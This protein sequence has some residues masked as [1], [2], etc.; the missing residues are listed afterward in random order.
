MQVEL[1]F[2]LEH[3]PV[4]IEE[5]AKKIIRAGENFVDLDLPS[6]SKLSYDSDSNMFRKWF[7]NESLEAIQL[8]LDVNSIM[9]DTIKLY[10]GAA[11][12]NSAAVKPSRGL[13][14]RG[15]S[16]AEVDSYIESGRTEIM[17]AWRFNVEGT[18]LKSVFDLYRLIRSGKLQP[19]EWWDIKPVE[20][21]KQ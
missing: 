7:G 16:Q 11:Y 20:E 14:R 3:V 18:N 8:F 6:G 21:N 5:E 12:L 19:T 10:E 17:P 13:Y 2:A 9:P 15:E 4:Q 1:F